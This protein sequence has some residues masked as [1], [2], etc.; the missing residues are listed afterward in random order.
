MEF[1]SNPDSNTPH[2]L[3]LGL[4]R[5]GKS[6]IQKV[7]F[8]KMPPNDT[9]YLG[10]TTKTDARPAIKSFIDL[11][12]WDCPGQIDYLEEGVFDAQ[13]IFANAGAIV[14]VIDAQDDFTDSLIRLQSTIEHAYKINPEINFEILIH[15]VDGLS[16]DNKQGTLDMISQQVSEEIAEMGIPVEPSYYL[17]SI[18]DHSVFEAFSKIIQ[19]LLP[20]LGT[21]E[22][23]L[24]AFAEKSG[25]EKAYLFDTL[26]KIYIATDASPVDMQSYEICSD[27]IDV[28][29]DFECIYGKRPPEMDEAPMV[30]PMQ[31]M[32]PQDDDQPAEDGLYNQSV[33]ESEGSSL[34][35][36]S[37]G[38][39][40]YLRE[41]NRLL[42]LIC[43]LRSDNLEKRGLIDYNFQC[44]K[45]AIVEIFEVTKG[46]RQAHRIDDGMARIQNGFTDSLRED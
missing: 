20:Q 38:M 40:L 18:Y 12:I 31:Y 30:A 24:T 29:I 7:V 11:Q 16:D 23:L 14:Y 8:A 46:A 17:T 4:R 26:T 25:I 1:E 2:L 45:K 35:R 21:L 13:N 15:K 27:M 41:V 9:L 22:N 36:L 5:S 34:I 43:L 37:N 10:T 6:S 19:K 28:I 39:V 32:M 44:F 3:L 33:V 42:L